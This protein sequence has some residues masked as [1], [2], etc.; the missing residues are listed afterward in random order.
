MERSSMVF[1]DPR[2]AQIPGFKRTR[3][4]AMLATALKNVTARAQVGYL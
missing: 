3:N 1:P 4:L 2:S